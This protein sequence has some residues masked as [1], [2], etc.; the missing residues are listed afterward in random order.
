MD[1]MRGGELFFH[2]RK[3]Y[4]FSHKR[5]QFYIAQITIAL[6][7][8]HKKGIVYRDLKPENILLDQNGN[9]RLADFGLSKD[10]MIFDD[11][12]NTFCGTAE[13][14]A[15]EII[16]R[17]GHDKSVDW[18]SLGV[19]MYEMLTG[20]APFHARNRK[21]LF[22]NI[23]M[24]EPDFTK[25]KF[26]PEEKDLI[27]KL[28]QM[29]PKNRI[30][31]S[32]LDAKELKHHPYF[33]GLNW[34]KLMRYELKAPFIPKLKSDKDLRNFDKMFTREKIKETPASVVQD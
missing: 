33:R 26:T 22:K 14:I 17:K 20:V 27:S 11:K 24:K 19:L 18:W 7:F 32:H 4:Q 5:T 6:E 8:L 28:L 31:N 10:G 15:P 34:D 2:L 25:Y 21:Q 12:T 16:L 23:L 9:L 3:D 30:C 13:Y 29:N 1:F